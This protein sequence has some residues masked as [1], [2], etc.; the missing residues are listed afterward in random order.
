MTTAAEQGESEFWARLQAEARELPAIPHFIAAGSHAGIAQPAVLRRGY[1]LLA[2]STGTFKSYLVGIAPGLSTLV[3]AGV[4]MAAGLG[5][6]WERPGGVFTSHQLQA[7]AIWT[8]WH[9]V[10]LAISMGV[11]GALFG[12]I[13]QRLLWYNAAWGQAIV[14]EEIGTS[15]RLAAM[16]MTRLHRLTFAAHQTEGYYR[17]NAEKGHISRAK[18]LLKCQSGVTDERGIVVSGLAGAVMTDLYHMEPGVGHSTDDP[19]RAYE[20]LAL[21]VENL[22]NQ[23]R[24][25]DKNIL[26]R[27]PVE[28]GFFI[29]AIVFAVLAAL[30]MMQIYSGEGFDTTALPDQLGG[31][32]GLG[33]GGAA[34]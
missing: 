19:G 24:N 13:W 2:E 1:Q 15:G 32:I 17:G 5:V 23:V 10:L 18:I 29:T 28:T 4:G 22:A 34:Q 14:L 12:I 20:A 11:A 6:D 8:I 30:Q 25:R 7:G 33:G 3:S 31:T 27:Y 26:R 16:T 21:R 9:S